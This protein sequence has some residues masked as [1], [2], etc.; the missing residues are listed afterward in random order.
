MVN[1]STV[2]YMIVKFCSDSKCPGRKPVGKFVKSFAV[3]AS[4]VPHPSSV[5]IM[6]AGMFVPS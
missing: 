1:L 3:V 4:T 6:R 2:S 5:T